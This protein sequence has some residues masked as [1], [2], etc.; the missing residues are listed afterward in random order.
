MLNCYT[1]VSLMGNLPPLVSR[2]TRRVSREIRVTEPWGV[3]YITCEKPVHI[4]KLLT[5]PVSKIAIDL[6]YLSTHDKPGYI[7]LNQDFVAKLT[8]PPVSKSAIDPLRYLSN[9]N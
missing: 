7:C 8:R 9:R 6:R 4:G 1:T 3:E 2:E 5:P